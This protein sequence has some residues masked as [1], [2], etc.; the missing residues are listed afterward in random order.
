MARE[1][2]LSVKFL[3]GKYD[4]LSSGASR[5]MTMRGALGQLGSEL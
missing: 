2:D 1:I 5:G 4:D 3:L